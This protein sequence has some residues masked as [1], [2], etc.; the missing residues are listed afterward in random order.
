MQVDMSLE[1]RSLRESLLAVMA[2]VGLLVIRG[3]EVDEMV[4][5]EFTP[6]K[7]F[8]TDLASE[9]LRV[10]FTMFFQ[11]LGVSKHDKKTSK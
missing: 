7:P 2:L 10:V 3:V 8:P 9:G 11:G 1:S 4:L 5:Q 6:C